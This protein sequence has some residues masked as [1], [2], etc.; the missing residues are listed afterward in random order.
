M[1]RKKKKEKKRKI[2]VERDWAPKGKETVALARSFLNFLPTIV[3][4]DGSFL[5][6]ARKKRKKKSFCHFRG[7]SPTISFFFLHGDSKRKRGRRKTCLKK[8]KKIR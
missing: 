8:K 5:V 3:S 4:L 2:K 7:D 1:C 6:A